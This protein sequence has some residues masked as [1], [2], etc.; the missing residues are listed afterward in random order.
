MT[1]SIGKGVNSP[2]K[3][4]PL[5]GNP[6]LWSSLLGGGGIMCHCTTLSY[7]STPPSPEGN[8]TRGGPPPPNLQS[9]HGIRKYSCMS[10]PIMNINILPH[11]P[12]PLINLLLRREYWVL[13][14]TVHKMQ[15]LILYV[16]LF[17]GVKIC[18]LL[19]LLN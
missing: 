9:L 14:K 15:H 5:R 13:G 17:F 3:L 4:G 19:L 6:L 7:E 16:L 10:H 12:P 8:T 18:F 11:Y 1:D 2:I